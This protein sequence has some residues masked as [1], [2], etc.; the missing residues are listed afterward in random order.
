[1]PR[2][3][4]LLFLFW[5]L[6]SSAAA[7]RLTATI[8][9]LY[10][11][12][13]E[14]AP[15]EDIRLLLPPGADPH[16][17]EPRWEALRTLRES[18]LVLAVGYETWLP[19]SLSPEKKLLLAEGPFKNPHLWLDLAR[20]RNFIER[21]SARLSLLCPARKGEIESRK[22]K[23]LAR[24]ARL[25]ALKK[26]L[27]LCRSRTVLVLGHAALEELLKG[28]SLKVV[29]LAGP[30]PESEVLPGDLSRAL[31]LARRKRL[32]A[33]F[34]LDP[35]FQRYVPLF[36]KEGIRVLKINPG[37]PVWPEDRGLSFLDLLQKDLLTL[38]NGLCL[39]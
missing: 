21:L 10:D 38:K 8:Y 23:L 2:T 22:R 15:E 34:L 25:E 37:L 20:L 30:H 13:R 9:P 39:S 31:T 27:S 14:L 7:L 1:M 6:V 32:P 26:E 4:F 28:T 19:R 18:D 12:A 35:A 24:M 16:H 29:S 17:F 3:F 33:V 11:L 5:N 36:R